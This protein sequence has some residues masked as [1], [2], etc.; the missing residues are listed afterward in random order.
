M[1]KTPYHQY[2]KSNE[3]NSLYVCTNFDHEQ[4]EIRKEKIII[5]N[6][7]LLCSNA[8]WQEQ[9]PFFDLRGFKMLIYNYRGHINSQGVDDIN[10][11][12]FH[13][14]SSDLSS[15]CEKLKLGEVVLFGHSMGVNVCLEFAKLFP[16]RVAAMILIGGTLFPP[17][18]FMFQS[19]TMNVVFP[20]VDFCQKEFPESLSVSLGKRGIQSTCSLFCSQ[21]WVSYEED[22]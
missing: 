16:K 12:T 5:F 10:K 6:Y 18:D 7:G 2:V 20:L 4:E 15:I 19:R 8:Y 17:E 3:G 21:K 13:S 9:I 14:I 22:S 1:F 11:I